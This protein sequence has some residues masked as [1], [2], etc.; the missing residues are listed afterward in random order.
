MEAQELTDL[1]EKLIEQKIACSYF[2]TN[3]PALLPESEREIAETKAK[4]VDLLQPL[5]T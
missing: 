4:L 2:R 3:V 5:F 1:I